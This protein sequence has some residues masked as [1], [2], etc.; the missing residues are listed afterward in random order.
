MPRGT[1]QGVTPSGSGHS[2]EGGA[3]SSTASPAKPSVPN[4]ERVYLNTDRE[5]WRETEGDYYSPS[6]HV[7]Q[8]GLIGIN[9][10]GWV[11]VRSLQDWH[12][13][14][15]TPADREAIARSFCEASAIEARRAETLQ[16]GSV[17][18]SAVGNAETPNPQG[19]DSNQ[20]SGND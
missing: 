7:T 5:L 3:A 12:A 15:I 11:A 16:D 18:E 13:L 8:S 6:I 14:A 4:A 20:G 1:N 17:H 2:P 9:V 19:Q 10:G